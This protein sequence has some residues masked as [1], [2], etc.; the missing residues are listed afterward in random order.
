MLQSL[1]LTNTP[2]C[3]DNTVY[4]PVHQL[5][6]TGSPRSLDLMNIHALAVVWTY[7]FMSPEYTP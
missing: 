5:T 3:G 1:W 7:V 4:L 2:L 6:D